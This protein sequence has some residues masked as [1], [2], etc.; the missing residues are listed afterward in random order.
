MFR[1]RMRA[2][3]NRA[4]NHERLAATLAALHRR[5]VAFHR[6]ARQVIMASSAQV[7]C[8]LYRTSLRRRQPRR[9]LLEPR[10]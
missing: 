10:F 7:R 5:C 3:S 8:P 2:R 4:I 1:N 6:T 9:A